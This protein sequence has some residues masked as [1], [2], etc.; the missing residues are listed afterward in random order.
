MTSIHLRPLSQ[1]E[2]TTI[3]FKLGSYAFRPTPPSPDYEQWLKR[4][5]YYDGTF[6]GVFDGDTALAVAGV[7][8]FYSKF[9]TTLIKYVILIA[10]KDF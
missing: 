6:I 8:H 5:A 4:T 9:Y 1:E 3:P 10:A 7:P 2:S